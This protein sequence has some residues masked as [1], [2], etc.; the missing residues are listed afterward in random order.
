M[1]KKRELII[2]VLSTLCLITTLFTVL[3]T[4]SSY[5]YDP[6]TDIDNDGSIDMADISIVIDNFMTSGTPMNKTALLLEVQT[7]RAH[8]ETYST[9]LETRSGYDWSWQ[10][11][12]GM[13]VQ[14]TLETSCTLL[15]MFSAEALTTTTYLELYA[16]ATVDSIAANPPAVTLT[17]LLD[18]ASHSFTFYKSNVAPG[19]HTVRIQWSFNDELGSVQIRTRTLIVTSLLQ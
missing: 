8:N 11:I 15:I 18:W 6:W 4:N 14:I 17:K 9:S 12:S 16:R 10:D 19:T 13:T 1:T 2:A 3:P 5:E 7:A